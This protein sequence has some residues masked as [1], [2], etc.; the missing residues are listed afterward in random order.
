MIWCGPA[1]CRPSSS[2]DAGCSTPS[3]YAAGWMTCTSNRGARDGQHLSPRRDR[4]RSIQFFGPSNK[5]R[6]AAGRGPGGELGVDAGWVSAVDGG[7]A[8]SAPRGRACPACPA[9]DTGVVDVAVEHVLAIGDAERAVAAVAHADAGVVG[10][11][12]VA[13]GD[14]DAAGGALGL[15]DVGPVAGEAGSVGDEERA[16]AAFAGV[17]LEGGPTGIGAG[18]GGVAGRAVPLTQACPGAGDRAAVGDGDVARAPGRR[19]ACSGR[20]TSSRRR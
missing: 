18:D 10:P 12:G 14:R 5:R 2:A 7:A 15:S 1:R 4:A 20:P 11:P 9:R 6:H 17:E 8:A 16:I 19:C 13:A 3:S